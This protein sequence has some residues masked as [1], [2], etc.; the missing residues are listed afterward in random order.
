MEWSIP[1]YVE[2]IIDRLEENGFSAYIVG[3]SVRDILIGKEPSDF[4]VTTDALPEEIEVIFKD[5]TTLEVGK[6]FGTVVVVQEEGIVEVTTFRSDGEYLDGRRPE[7]VFFSKN[8]FD[9]LSRRDFTINAMAYNKNTGLIDYF[10]GM[11]DLEKKKI[12]AVGNPQERF[13]EDYLRIMR[14]LRFAT[15][16]EFY[17]EEE[18]YNSCKEYSEYIRDISIERIREEFF[19]IVLSKTPSYGINLMKD[20][21]VLDVIL[22]EITKAIEFNQHNS[23]HDK[24]VFS[25]TLCVLD[26]TSPIL[27]LRLAALFHDIGKPYTLTIDEKGIG[28]FYEHDKLGAKMAKEILQRWKSS[29]EL[30]EKVSILIYKH[31]TQHANL[32]EKG[33]KRLL[34][35]LG[36]DEIFTLLELQ[37]ADRS[38]SHEEADIEDLLEREESIKNIIQNKEA[39]DKNQLAISGY[40]VIELGYKQGKVIGEILDYLLEKVLE[41][42]ELNHKEKLIETVK[43]NFNQVKSEK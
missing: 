27:H 30:I 43:Q 22:P 1:T 16:L 12:K 7:R 35:A 15:Q 18:T 5:Y 39:Y 10:N 26:K 31:M 36:E 41:K 11:E 6:K 24:D 3:G 37:K 42:P 25:H 20:T 32:K 17:I 19:K 8:I 9:D 29:N 40:D 23:H 28:H 34:A 38:C 4:D 21:G 13:E 2:N 33:L 14:A